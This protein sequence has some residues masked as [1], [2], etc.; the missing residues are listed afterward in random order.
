MGLEIAHALAGMVIW[1]SF[2]TFLSSAGPFRCN[3]SIGGCSRLRFPLVGYFD[4]AMHVTGRFFEGRYSMLG[5]IGLVDGVSR[6]GLV[7]GSLMGKAH[8]SEHR[9]FSI[10]LC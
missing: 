8:R 9:L 2:I 7:R 1:K 10:F 4:K 6:S 3:D 5:R